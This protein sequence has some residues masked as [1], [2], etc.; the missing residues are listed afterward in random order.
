MRVPLHIVESRR[1]KLAELIA[2]R[3]YLPVQELCKELRVS[4]ATLRRDLASLEQERKITRT[5]GGALSEYN[6]RFPSFHQRLGER[7]ETKRDLAWAAREL[8]PAGGTIFLDAGTTIFTLA[9]L[10]KKEPVT[11]LTVVTSNLPAGELLAGVDGIE[12]Y[13]IAGK[14]LPR[15]S[16]LLG[17]TAVRSLRFWRFDFGFFSAEAINAEG[18]FNTR[19]EIVTLQQAALACSQR[20]VF[21]IAQHKVGGH[22]SQFLAGWD[23]LDLLLTDA[24]DKALKESHIKLPAERVLHPIRKASPPL[25]KK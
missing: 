16:I 7:H 24:P 9:S 13:L 11:P 1:E 21:C 15:Q 3:G 20:S 23:E 5:Y 25:P 18:I 12:V 19:P 14:L 8:I 10:L 2:Q 6:Q 4:E 22:A 17:D